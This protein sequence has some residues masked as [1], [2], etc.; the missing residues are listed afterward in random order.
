MASRCACQRQLEPPGGTTCSESGL[1]DCGQPRSCA[2]GLGWGW[3]GSAAGKTMQGG[4][5]GEEGVGFLLSRR[6]PHCQ[7]PPLPRPR[8]HPG[9]ARLDR[10]GPFFASRRARMGLVGHPLGAWGAAGRGSTEVGGGPALTSLSR[11]ARLLRSP[12]TRCSGGSSIPT[13]TTAADPSRAGR[14]GSRGPLAAPQG[15]SA[16]GFL[17]PTRPGRGDRLDGGVK[18]GAFARFGAAGGLSLGMA[19]ATIMVAGAGCLLGAWVAAWS[20]PVRL[21]TRCIKIPEAT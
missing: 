7:F 17:P 5:G 16:G 1:A 2:L 4:Q 12:G 8:I 11:L 19:G 15:G 3:G 13:T 14:A 21:S 18:H 6:T 20:R 9:P 10:G